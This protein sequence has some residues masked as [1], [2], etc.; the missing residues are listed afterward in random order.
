MKIRQCLAVMFI[1]CATFALPTVSFGQEVAVLPA[2]DNAA[3]IAAVRA[4]GIKFFSAIADGKVEEAKTCCDASLLDDL[5]ELVDEIKGEP[6]AAAFMR[7]IIVEMVKEAEI[8][9]KGD[10]AWLID[11]GEK[12]PFARKVNGKWILSEDE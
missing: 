12:E 11:E 8:I 3:E 5:Q 2:Q 9:V 7:E 6:G 4:L 1:A 10:R